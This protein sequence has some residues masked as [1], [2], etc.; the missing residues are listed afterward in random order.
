MGAEKNKIPMQRL[1]IVF[2]CSVLVVACNPR[3]TIE[4][5][6]VAKSEEFVQQLPGRDP[7][8]N[9]SRIEVWK[10][11]DTSVNYFTSI[12]NLSEVAKLCRS[13]NGA[14]ANAL[15]FSI[16]KVRCHG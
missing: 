5:F 15:A 6:S 7:S 1:W 2:V 4:K 16:W 13:E 8:Q 9:V 12:R 3:T 11:N 14:Q 10:F